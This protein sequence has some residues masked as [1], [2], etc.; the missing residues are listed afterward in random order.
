MQLQVSRLKSDVSCEE[1]DSIRQNL[2]LDLISIQ[3]YM[4]FRRLIDANIDEIL[5]ANKLNK[6][7]VSFSSEYYIL[8]DYAYYS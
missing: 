7:D 6:F 3:I 5:L 2:S 4:E 8:T 1:I